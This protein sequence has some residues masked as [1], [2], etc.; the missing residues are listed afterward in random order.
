MVKMSKGL[1]YV[2]DLY[3]I[4]LRKEMG[5]VSKRQQPDHR[6]DNMHFVPNLFA[7]LV[8]KIS[9]FLVLR[10]W[11]SSALYNNNFPCVLSL[12]WDTAKTIHLGNVDTVCQVIASYACEGII[13]FNLPFDPVTSTTE[14]HDKWYIY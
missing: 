7:W 6:T 3:L 12:K 9:V 5:N 13:H 1:K 11:R 2:N 4:K 14:C 8:L 10:K